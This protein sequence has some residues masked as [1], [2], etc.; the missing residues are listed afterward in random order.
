MSANGKENALPVAQLYKQ[1]CEYCTVGALDSSTFGKY[2]S[3]L[4]GT[5]I[6]RTK[7]GGSD[8]KNVNMLQ[9][10]KTFVPKLDDLRP[11]TTCEVITHMVQYQ[12]MH[13]P[14]KEGPATLLKPTY[15]IVNGENLHTG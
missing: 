2:V 9:G 7:L 8:R 1:Y 5:S 12:F 14:A 13:I 3:A 10:I 11:L 4:F 15:H 6:K